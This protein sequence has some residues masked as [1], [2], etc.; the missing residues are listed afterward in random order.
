MEKS[1]TAVE[2]VNLLAA[3]KDF[4]LLD[5]RRKED[6]DKAPETIGGAQWKNP[7]DMDQ[8]I[9]TLPEQREVIVYCVRG[10]SV[11][12]SVQ[13]RLTDAGFKAQYVVGGLE[14]FAK[15]N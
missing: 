7:V 13:Q 4:T 15:K 3:G 10:G 12:Q 1:L 8:W 11:S 9:Q 6:F 2:L 5:V 14:A